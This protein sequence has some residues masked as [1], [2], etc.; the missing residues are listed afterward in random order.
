[1]SNTYMV[2]MGDHTAL[3]SQRNSLLRFINTLE[4]CYNGS[5]RGVRTLNISGI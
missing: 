2:Y 1:M 3:L 4:T 5:T